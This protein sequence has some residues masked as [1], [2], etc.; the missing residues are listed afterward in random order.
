MSNPPPKSAFENKSMSQYDRKLARRRQL[1]EMEAAA[2]GTQPSMELDLSWSSPPSS[3]TS[4]VASTESPSLPPR[5]ADSPISVNSTSSTS[6]A[7]LRSRNQDTA[8][9][10]LQDEEEIR[11]DLSRAS[12]RSKV[13]NIGSKNTDG[14]MAFGL[15]RPS[16]AASHS[17]NL[18]DHDAGVYEDPSSSS[19]ASS[20]VDTLR[21]L[22]ARAGSMVLDFGTMRAGPN[23]HHDAASSLPEGDSLYVDDDYQQHQKR[24]GKNYQHGSRRYRRLLSLLVAIAV[25]AS[26]VF[27]TVKMLAQYSETKAEKKLRA[28]NDIRFNAIL[29]QILEQGVSHR[30]VFLKKNRVS[31]ELH[32]LRWIAYSDP[33][34]LEPKDSM[35]L[36]RY[37]LT[38]FFFQSFLT[39]QSS[40]G[41][42]KAIEHGDEQW[43]G[44][45]NPGWIQHDHWLSEKGIC[46]WYGVECEPRIDPGD[47]LM[48]TQYDM[49]Q[50][51][52]SLNLTQNHVYGFI[53]PEFRGLEHMVE[54]QLSYNRMHGSLPAALGQ[55]K[56][57]QWL[58]VQRNSLTGHVPT[59]LGFLQTAKHI[60]L[61]SNRLSG[62]IPTQLNRLYNVQYLAADHNQL[63]GT[64]PDF[65]QCQKMTTLMLNDNQLK[66][67][68]PF[69][70]GRAKHLKE[71]SL[72]HN[73]LTGTLPPELESIHDLEV[74]KVNDNL[75]KG[76]LPEHIFLKL[77]RLREFESQNNKFTGTIPST[78]GALSGLSKLHLNSNSLTGTMVPE[79]FGKLPLLQSLHLNE[80]QLS[81]SIPT[82]F[83]HFAYLKELWLNDN[84]I[85]GTLPSQLSSLT[86]LNSLYLENNRLTGQVPQDLAGCINMETARLYGNDFSGTMP[87][88]ICE[89]TAADSEGKLSFLAANC[90]VPH[91][92]KDDHSWK[93]N[94]KCQHVVQCECCH[95]CY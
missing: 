7:Y 62:N 29:D 17:V 40:S 92:C 95:K 53:P 19:W 65:G 72:H 10:F 47:G 20:A 64:I 87:A 83:G 71:L 24:R 22:S 75:F 58:D 4:T 68:L 66:G 34:K 27:L 89:L 70:L 56:A 16:I 31:A 8:R 37:A 73:Q 14:S 67:E 79:E 9:R 41:K 57:L 88:S 59:E 28:Q 69:I 51:V 38:V 76:K 33:A 55:M 63:T 39:F 32:A 1:L 90:L 81:G 21:M 23:I 25:G 3:T 91:D 85:S 11:F 35:I 82:V 94:S 26:A 2:S 6:S 78:F 80:N 54:L 15:N 45:P 50:P 36:Q 93:T 46:M 42:Q 84:K 30:N 48:H 74:L 13:S 86:K 5:N 43:E 61:S 18:M 44:V 52:I 60:S 49:N 12:N 77:T